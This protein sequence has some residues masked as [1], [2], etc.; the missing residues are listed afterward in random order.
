M[1]R[2]FEIYHE[3]QGANG[4]S[5][6]CKSAS[7][8]AEKSSQYALTWLRFRKWMLDDERYQGLVDLTVDIDHCENPHDIFKSIKFPIDYTIIEEYLDTALKKGDDGLKS[9]SS[10][11]AFWNS[12]THAGKGKLN[13]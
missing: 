3:S 10:S 13:E 4:V 5:A 6:A 2:R 8:L 12:Y 7:N 11:N 1:K 9:V